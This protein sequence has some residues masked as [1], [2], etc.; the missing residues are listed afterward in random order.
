MTRI[1]DAI[2]IPLDQDDGRGRVFRAR[3]GIDQFAGAENTPA[4]TV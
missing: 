3:L 2:G 4:P 1:A